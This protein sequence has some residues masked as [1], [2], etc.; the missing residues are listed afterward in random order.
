MAYDDDY[1]YGNAVDD[2]GYD[3]DDQFQDYDYPQGGLSL[4][5]R[6]DS[7]QSRVGDS[8]SLAKDVG[9]FF[10]ECVRLHEHRKEVEAMTQ[11]KLATTVAKYKTAEN[12]ITS[13]FSERSE[14][15][16]KYYAVLDDAVSKGDRELIISAMSNIS[17]IVV[18]SPMKDLEKLCQ[19]FDESLDNLLDYD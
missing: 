8:L 18:S 4:I 15:L 9:G 7:F 13:S 16:Q 3:V 14:A 10:S 17:G 19:S 11:E 2:Y 12:F 5:Q 6:F 1:I